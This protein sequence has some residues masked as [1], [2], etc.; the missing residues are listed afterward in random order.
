MAKNPT[1]PIGFIKE[2]CQDNNFEKPTYECVKE[3]GPA[4][5]REFT[6]CCL[7]PE[8]NLSET[9]SG[10]TKKA[11]KKEA[12]LKVY[13]KLRKAGFTPQPSANEEN[14]PLVRFFSNCVIV[15]LAMFHSSSQNRQFFEIPFE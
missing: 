10:V 2:I 7:V 11:A 8:L 14:K 4:H 1:E 15:Y 5:Q 6:I 13:K 12:A 3:D 9:G